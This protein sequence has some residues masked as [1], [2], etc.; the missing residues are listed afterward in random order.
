M[1]GRDGWVLCN[2][3]LSGWVRMERDKGC[4]HQPSQSVLQVLHACVALFP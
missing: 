4:M 1:R 3:A 2:V